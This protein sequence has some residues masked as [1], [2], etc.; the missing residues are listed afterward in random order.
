MDT[1]RVLLGRGISCVERPRTVHSTRVNTVACNCVIAGAE[2]HGMKSVSFI[3]CREK[4]S[5]AISIYCALL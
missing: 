3:V 5:L 4:W 1:I 2:A